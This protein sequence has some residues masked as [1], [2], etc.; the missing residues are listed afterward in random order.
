[1]SKFLLIIITHLQRRA[2]HLMPAN[3][4]VLPCHQE[5]ALS[6]LLRPMALRGDITSVQAPGRDFGYAAHAE[7]SGLDGDTDSKA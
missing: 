2:S 1:M 5:N 7:G 3:M 6:D 4:S